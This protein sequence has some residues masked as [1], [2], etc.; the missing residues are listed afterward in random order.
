VNIH[1]VAL[2]VAAVLA[3]A[4]SACS[5][6]STPYTLG[7]PEA[8]VVSTSAWSLAL[9][10]SDV[11]WS[12]DDGVYAASKTPIGSPRALVSNVDMRFA[13]I[14]LDGD[15]VL[16]ATRTSLDAVPKVGGPT[17]LLA[18]G[19]GD[20][21]YTMVAANGGRLF[22]VDF[23]AG[24]PPNHAGVHVTDEQ[25]GATTRLA[26]IPNFAGGPLGVDAD[27]LWAGRFE[28]D[29]STGAVTEFSNLG[30]RT[31]VEVITITPDA[32]YATSGTWEDDFADGDGEVWR[33]PNDGSPATVLAQGLFAPSILVADDVNVF[34]FDAQQAKLSYVPVTG[35]PLTTLAEVRGVRS[36]AVDD[37]GIYWATP[38]GIFRAP[39][40][41]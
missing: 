15:E 32:T 28:I 41:G 21:D 13:Q 22:W 8:V 35:G 30:P 27:T 16:Y 37:T 1:R 7:A 38:E 23:G 14:S 18:N 36:L 19:D 33:V 6:S 2:S 20:P 34:V 12:A 17:R 3:C 24:V 40:G 5:T 9:D 10:E 4:S 29:A 39:K 26:E 11:V 31:N 25:T